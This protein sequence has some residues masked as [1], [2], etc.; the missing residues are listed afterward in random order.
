MLKKH[1]FVLAA[2][3]VIGMVIIPL[4]EAQT[5][6][7]Q[8]E[9]EQIAKR[10]VNGLSPKDR[11]RVIQIMTDVYVAQGMSKQQAASL[12]EMAANSMFS[13]DVGEMTPEQRRE[14]EEQDRM[15]QDFEQ[16]QNQPQQVQKPQQPQQQG[17]T[18]GWPAAAMFRNWNISNMKQP[19]GT[20]SSYTNSNYKLE[21]YLTGANSNTLQELKR[22]IETSLKKQME[23]GGNKYSISF[24]VSKF[25]NYCVASIRLEG[26]VIV[27][28]FFVAAG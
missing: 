26:N 5:Q 13:T 11:Q 14:F 20:Q 7:Q 16:R 27:L 15:L 25:N 6:A 19:A 1:I 10:S 22:Q 3:L 21:I 18:A 17:E 4:A 9:L 2:L 8:R 24:D 28:E 23:G 12:A